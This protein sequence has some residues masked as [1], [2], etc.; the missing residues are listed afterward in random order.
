MNKNVPWTQTK[1]YSYSTASGI[2]NRQFVYDISFLNKTEI[3]ALIW[4]GASDSSNARASLD[5]SY[6][7]TEITNMANVPGKMTCYWYFT[8]RDTDIPFYTAFFNGPWATGSSYLTIGAT[9]YQASQLTTRYKIF[10]QQTFTLASGGNKTISKM[11]KYRGR[12]IEEQHYGGAS[13][14]TVNY[15]GLT[16]G[17]C[18]VGHSYAQGT[19]G[20]DTG[21]TLPQCP[22]T[23]FGLRN[24]SGVK[25][26]QV[27]I[28]P[29][30]INVAKP[31]DIVPVSTVLENATGI[32]YV[33][34]Y[35]G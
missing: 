30:I 16:W 4:A 32:G 25:F 35:I 33:R 19:Q 6:L 13:T 12:I 20:I 2:P 5:S 21:P 14:S 27:N 31:T 1:L 9:P 3:N 24:E 17:V 34:Q 7:R 29:D 11:I 18:I 22:E 15:G 23:L 26:K 28:L 8:R 10:Y